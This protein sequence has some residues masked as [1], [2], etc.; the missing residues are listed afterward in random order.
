MSLSREDGRARPSHNCLRSL[1]SPGPES[2]QRGS[3]PSDRLYPRRVRRTEGNR[4]TGGR[5][6]RSGPQGPDEPGP[7]PASV[8]PVHRPHRR[9][10]VLPRHKRT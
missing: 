10:C 8:V 7:G 4:C 9:P 2:T 1:P 6:T 5:P 3:G